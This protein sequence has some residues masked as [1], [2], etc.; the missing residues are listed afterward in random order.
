MITLNWGTFECQ[1]VTDLPVLLRVF[2][3]AKKEMEKGVLM[4]VEL[5]H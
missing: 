2:E 5:F 4:S 1:K 3:K